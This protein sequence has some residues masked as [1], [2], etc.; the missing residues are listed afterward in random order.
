ML[1]MVG[2]QERLADGFF[3]RGKVKGHKTRSFLNP[4]MFYR[5]AKLQQAVR[6]M[7]A[8]DYRLPYLHRRN[9]LKEDER[10]APSERRRARAL[11]GSQ[12]LQQ[13]TQIQSLSP[14]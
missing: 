12:V 14:P 4:K 13:G 7:Y 11:F 9:F 3:P 5:N 8:E 1:Q 6:E 2:G 10:K